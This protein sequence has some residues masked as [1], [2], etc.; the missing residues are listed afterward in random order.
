MYLFFM[1]FYIKIYYSIRTESLIMTPFP[2][3]QYKEVYI[4]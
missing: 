1:H 2:P 4:L 3:V